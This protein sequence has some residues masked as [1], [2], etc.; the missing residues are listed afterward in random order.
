[1][2]GYLFLNE[3]CIFYR[4]LQAKSLHKILFSPPTCSTMELNFCLDDRGSGVEQRDGLR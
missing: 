4:K 2:G 3:M 1:M